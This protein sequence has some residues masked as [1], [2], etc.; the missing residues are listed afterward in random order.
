VD[1][2]LTVARRCP[3]IP[4]LFVKAWSLEDGEASRLM[5][6]L[7]SMPNVTLLP[8]T[9][10]M[11]KIYARTRLMLIPSKWEEAY[12]RIATE[13]QFSGIPAVATACGGLPEAVGPA[14]LLIDRDE[15]DDVWVQAVRR[16]WDDRDE[17][18]RYSES[19]REYSRRSEI[20]F[21][22]QIDAWE[23]ELAVAAFG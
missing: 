2:A 1:V 8:S 10:D 17:Y 4:F 21:E 23:A 19:A 3:D 9:D 7:R 16:M 22:N 14:G 18:E 12:G 6:Q 5:S 13:A 15:S 11:R 20:Q